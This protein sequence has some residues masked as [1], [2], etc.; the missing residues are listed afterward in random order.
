MEGSEAEVMNTVTRPDEAYE[1]PQGAIHVLKRTPQGPSDYLVVIYEKRNDEGYI[2][3]A[4]FVSQKRKARRY[5]WFKR[6]K[7]F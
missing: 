1:D 5:R 7:P 3:T 2:R 6:L 4:Y